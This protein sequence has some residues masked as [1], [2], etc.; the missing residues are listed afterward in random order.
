MIVVDT[1]V[2]VYLHVKGT[3]TEQ[4]REVYRKDPHWFAPR[5]WRSEFLNA[6]AL[7]VRK[8]SLNMERALDALHRAER[9]MQRRQLDVSSDAV[10]RLATDSGCSAYDCEYVSLAQTLGVP[11]VTSDGELLLKFGAVAV[12][13][14]AFCLRP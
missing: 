7:Y 5:L 3:E 6:L 14:Q 4:A 11:L 12:S 1:N 9:M 8:G 10:L 2:L 13:M